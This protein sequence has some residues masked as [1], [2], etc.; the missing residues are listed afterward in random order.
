[1]SGTTP[2]SPLKEWRPGEA[3]EQELQE[4]DGASEMD[5]NLHGP[6]RKENP[7][8]KDEHLGETGEKATRVR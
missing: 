8:K 7:E 5:T 3:A 4:S 2:H 6:P 1:M